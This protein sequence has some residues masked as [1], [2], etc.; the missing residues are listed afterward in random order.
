MPYTFWSRALY[1][2]L[3]TDGLPALAL[4]LD[5]PELDVMRRKPRQPRAS[6]FSRPVVALIT[7]GGAWSAVVN[8]G[9]FIWA[10]RSRGSVKEAMTMVFVSLVL[11]QF[12]KAYNYRS[13]RDSLL[14][15]PFANKWLNLTI[16]WELGL[17]ALIIKVPWLREPFGPFDLRSEDWLVAF[18]LAF[19]I[20]P[21]LELAKWM[22]R[23]GCAGF[24]ANGV[25]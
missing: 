17:L 7:V 8:P 14:N 20:C 13:D 2:N 10:M 21:A 9:L 19:T 6:I 24:S 25:R 1:V 23:R 4:S 18:G 3:A 16:V 5:P 15:R 22:H 12:F 11:I